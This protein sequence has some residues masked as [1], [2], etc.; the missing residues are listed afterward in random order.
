M[1]RGSTRSSTWATGPMRCV[2]LD[3]PHYR[4]TAPVGNAFRGKRILAG[5]ARQ[6]AGQPAR[7]GRRGLQR[8]RWPDLATAVYDRNSVALLL[9]DRQRRL[10]A[11]ADRD[12]A[13]AG[14]SPVAD[15]AASV[16]SR[17]WPATST[18]SGGMDLAVVNSLSS[19]VAI[20]LDFDGQR[21]ASERYVTVGTLPDCDRRRRCGRRRRPGSGRHQRMEQHGVDPAQRRPRPVYADA[22]A[23]AVGN[24]PFGVATG[25]FNEDG[26]TGLGRGRLRHASAGRRLGRRAACCW[27]TAGRFVSVRHGVPRGVRAC[28]RWSP[29]IWTAMDIWTW[30]SPTS[31][32]T[33]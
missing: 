21:F 17:C 2:S 9:N 18:A 26:R 8:R 15:R 30:P 19:N 24:H 25:D 3:V 20:L 4:Q 10:S 23:P 33:T 22:A 16:P 32:R 31:C 29:R 28:R 7:R 1:K 12:P 13:G 27:P 6:P 11:A 5:R 14:G